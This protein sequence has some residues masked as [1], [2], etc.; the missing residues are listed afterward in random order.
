MKSSFRRLDGAV[1]WLRSGWRPPVVAAFVL[2]HLTIGVPYHLLVPEPGGSEIPGPEAPHIVEA[3]MNHWQ[4]GARR[5]GC[6]RVCGRVG[7]KECVKKCERDHR[8]K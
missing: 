1:R 6:L 3:G 4:I 8:N 2:I 7:C 5:G